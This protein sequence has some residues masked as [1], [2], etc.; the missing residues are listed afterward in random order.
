L[1]SAGI[2][3]PLGGRRPVPIAAAVAP[4]LPGNGAFIP[5]QPFRNLHQYRA[6]SVQIAYDFS[7]IQSKM[8]FHRGAPFK[9]DL[10]EQPYLNVPAMFSPGQ[11]S[12]MLHFNFYSRIYFIPRI[13]S[14]PTGSRVAKGSPYFAPMTWPK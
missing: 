6:V 4:Q 5:A 11:R 3:L 13:V 2:R 12:L 8:T 14:N 9:E 7:L 10:I 1:A